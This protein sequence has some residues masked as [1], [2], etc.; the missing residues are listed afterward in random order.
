MRP[1]SA[2]QVVAVW[3]RGLAEPPPERALTLLAAAFPDAGPAALAALP[4][5][6]RDRR[7]LR[8][9][10]ALFGPTLHA[11]AACP[12]CADPL[13]FALP[14]D[15]LL[16]LPSDVPGPLSL[17]VEGWR[18]R[19]RPVD[20]DALRAALAAPDDARRALLLACVEAVALADAMQPTGTTVPE[21]VLCHLEAALADADPAADLV[22]DL[23]CPACATP[24]HAPFDAAAFVW[25]E[26]AALARR[27]LRE[28]HAL[29]RAYGW[30]E[31]DVLALGAV[32]RAFYLDLAA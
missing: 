29:A 3:E 19:F 17:D 30:R 13:E 32:R 2:Q 5:G 20:T 11:V 8:L 9:R 10:A 1:L 14:A 26:V 23:T 21:P 4:L 25:A 16:A 6:E 15:G 22:L 12:A 28:V 18:L 24:F 31:A 7:L 27:L